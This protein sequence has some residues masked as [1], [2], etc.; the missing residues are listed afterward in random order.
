MATVI[1]GSEVV[2]LWAAWALAGAATAL[3]ILYAVRTIPQT[4]ISGLTLSPKEESEA[5]K[6]AKLVSESILASAWL[7]STDS[8]ASIDMT[9]LEN[10]P[11][12][13]T[14]RGDESDR[15]PAAMF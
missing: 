9:S 2:S 3:L 14:S 11:Q 1:G 7:Q 5:M 4:F 6:A 8:D 10:Y 13:G 15:A 12:F